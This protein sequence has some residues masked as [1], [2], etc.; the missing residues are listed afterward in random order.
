MLKNVT[1]TGPALLKISRKKCPP[2]TARKTGLRNK[3]IITV[4]SR[5]VR[6]QKSKT[7]TSRGWEAIKILQVLY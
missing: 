7:K 1:S 3:I 5:Y 2:A 6:L 4:L